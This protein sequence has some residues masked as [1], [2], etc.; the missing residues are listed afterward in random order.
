MRQM[1]W[2]VFYGQSNTIILVGLPR[3]RH[4]VLIAVVDPEG[5]VFTKQTVTFRTPGK[6]ARQ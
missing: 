5:N 3:G 4:K 2:D 6:P 1:A